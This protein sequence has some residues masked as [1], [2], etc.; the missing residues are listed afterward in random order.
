M[1]ADTKFPPLDAAEVDVTAQQLEFV[2]LK[3]DYADYKDFK[4]AAKDSEILELQNAVKSL[5]SVITELQR[6]VELRK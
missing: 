5:T 3:Q 2:N 6:K 1:K 4:E